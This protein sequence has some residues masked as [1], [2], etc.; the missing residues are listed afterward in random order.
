MSQSDSDPTRNSLFQKSWRR[1]LK[2]Y[3]KGIL[4]GAQH[5]SA[6]LGGGL[7]SHF[8]L[9]TGSSFVV[10]LS[11][12]RTFQELVAHLGGFFFGCAER[13]PNVFLGGVG[14]SARQEPRL[15]LRPPQAVFLG[16]MKEQPTSEELFLFEGFNGRLGQSSSSRLVAPGRSFK[17]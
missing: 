9:E 6:V 17:F 10:K 13:K 11:H 4:G 12:F 2:K 8:A 7:G 16:I 1:N 14:I 5:S 15:F 3:A